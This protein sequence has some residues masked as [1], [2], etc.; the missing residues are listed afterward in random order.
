MTYFA[1]WI[2]DEN[3]LPQRYR[4]MALAKSVHDGFDY[5]RPSRRSYL[6]CRLV[7]WK[8]WDD[9]PLIQ[10]LQAVPPNIFHDE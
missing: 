2:S 5:R 7:L 1:Y 3:Y 10:F 8:D 4:D 9:F 6:S